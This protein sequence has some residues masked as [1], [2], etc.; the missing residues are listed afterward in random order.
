MPGKQQAVSN[1]NELVKAVA[2]LA[3][4]LGLEAQEQV[5]VARRIWG[6]ERNIDVV[7]TDPKSRKRLGIECKFQDSKGTAEEKIPTTIKDISAWPIPGI[8]VFTGVGFSENM[9]SFLISTGKAV[10][11][12][13]LEPWLRLFFGLPLK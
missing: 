10:E 2:R 4:E 13:E 9:K 5:K 12:L 11:F 3:S 1:G 6:A 8:V 7:L